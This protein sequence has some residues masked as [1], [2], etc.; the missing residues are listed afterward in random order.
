[1]SIPSSVFLCLLALYVQW[2]LRRKLAPLLFEDEQPDQVREHGASPVEKAQGSDSAQRKAAN[3][4]TEQG[5]AVSS[6][7]TLLDHLATLTLNEGVM[8]AQPNRPLILLAE[9]TPL[10]QK[11]FELL[12]VDPNPGANVA[13]SQPP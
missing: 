4:R 9:A 12:D 10:Q 8:P 11:A 13:I 2:H 7:E 5:L 1:M 3:K 6:L